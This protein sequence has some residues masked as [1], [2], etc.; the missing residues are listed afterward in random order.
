MGETND[1]APVL[2]RCLAGAMLG[3]VVGSLILNPHSTHPCRTVLLR[4]E[5][6]CYRHAQDSAH[7]PHPRSTFATGEIRR[8]THSPRPNEKSYN[9]SLPMSTRSATEHWDGS[10]R[11]MEHFSDIGR[12][13]TQHMSSGPPAD[14][15]PYSNRWRERT[16][17][18]KSRSQVSFADCCPQKQQDDRPPSLRANAWH[19]ACFPPATRCATSADKVPRARAAK[20]VGESTSASLW[21]ICFVCWRFLMRYFLFRGLA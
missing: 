15:R 10:V 17:E 9:F 13:S 14:T 4:A 3:L 5:Y 6:P 20:A 7:Q 12:D 16:T 21:P 2:L 19:R 1:A 8:A 11:Q 18:R